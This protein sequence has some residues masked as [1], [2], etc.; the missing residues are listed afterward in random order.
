MFDSYEHVFP[1]FS[2]EVPGGRV[3]GEPEKMGTQ[4]NLS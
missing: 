1:L 2:F 4:S 3:P